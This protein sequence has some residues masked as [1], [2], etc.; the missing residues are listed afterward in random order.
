[1]TK[2]EAYGV[3]AEFEDA[4][5]LL[6]AAKAARL[7]GYRRMEAYSPYPIKELDEVIPSWNMLPLLFSLPGSREVSSDTTCN[8]SLR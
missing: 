3:A 7:A 8:T 1:M 6:T 4:E 2:P 5:Q